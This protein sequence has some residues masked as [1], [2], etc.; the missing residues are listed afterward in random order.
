M[1]QP[2]VPQLPGEIEDLKPTLKKK[3]P[4][5]K[6]LPELDEEGNVIPPIPK[7]RGRIG[8]KKGGQSSVTAATGSGDGLN[9][10]VVTAPAKPRAKAAA[11]GKGKGKGRKRKTASDDEEEA[12]ETEAEPE[13]EQ[14]FNPVYSDDE[15]GEPSAKR[16]R[17]SEVSSPVFFFSS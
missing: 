2:L 11:K 3:T 17:P 6:K 8:V 14:A 9:G 10:E 4:R 1:N 5:V 7:K 13:D 12:A 16:V 15:A